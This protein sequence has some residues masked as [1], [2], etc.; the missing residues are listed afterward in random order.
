MS[1]VFGSSHKI[2]LKGW[3]VLKEF[4]HRTTHHATPS[5]ARLN[6]APLCAHPRRRHAMFKLFTPESRVNDVGWALVLERH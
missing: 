2:Y 4:D 1:M 6:P 3:W 5:Y